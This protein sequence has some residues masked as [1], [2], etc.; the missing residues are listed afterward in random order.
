MLCLTKKQS[1][2]SNI[3]QTHKNAEPNPRTHKYVQTQT[4]TLKCNNLPPFD[5]AFHNLSI[6]LHDHVGI[7]CSLKSIQK[8]QQKGRENKGKRVETKLLLF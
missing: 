6:Q 1:H 8:V 2:L 5:L 3:T 7:T 4:Y